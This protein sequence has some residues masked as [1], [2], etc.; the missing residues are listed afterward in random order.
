MLNDSYN[1]PT[2]FLDKLW[3]IIETDD[4][5]I[6]DWN[7]ITEFWSN[8][9]Q[10]KSEPEFHKVTLIPIPFPIHQDELLAGLEKIGLE[11]EKK[12]MGCKL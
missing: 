3:S 4:I 6:H 11:N 1:N 5:H 9:L 7:N 10:I 2:A 12:I 8:I